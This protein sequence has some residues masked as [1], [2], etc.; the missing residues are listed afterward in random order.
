MKRNREHKASPDPIG[1]YQEWVDNRYNPGHWVG[2][3][4]PPFLDALALTKSQRTAVASA[5]IAGGVLCIAYAAYA[6]RSGESLDY[7]I[8]D[9]VFGLFLSVSGL[10]LLKSIRRAGP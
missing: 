5:V 7:V 10:A 4:I 6:L 2:G 9:A 1:D 3:K 8:I